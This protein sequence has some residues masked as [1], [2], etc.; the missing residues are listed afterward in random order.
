MV[1]ML[2]LLYLLVTSKVISAWV[3]ICD[4]AHSWLFYNAAA[5]GDQAFSI[6]T[7]LLTHLD[8]E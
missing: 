6:M 5:L 3:P 2:M 7:Y 4:N 1:Q 8:I